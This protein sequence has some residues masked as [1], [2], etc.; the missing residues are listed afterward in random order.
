M[1][2]TIVTPSEHEQTSSVEQSSTTHT[3]VDT[4]TTQNTG[5]LNAGT[6][7]T[8]LVDQNSV[9][10]DGLTSSS[11]H[12]PN[13]IQSAQASQS[14]NTDINSTLMSDHHLKSNSELIQHPEYKAIQPIAAPTI[15]NAKDSKDSTAPQTQ[16]PDTG[17]ASQ[18]G[19]LWGTI[20][21]IAGIFTL[22]WRKRKST[23]KK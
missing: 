21:L 1:P 2:I 4:Q 15:Q 14:E 17:K 22:R 11:L 9:L 7:G 16:L 20:A 3:E 18:N 12:Q 8:A 10:Q 23:D 19:S 13:I 5:Q 6:C